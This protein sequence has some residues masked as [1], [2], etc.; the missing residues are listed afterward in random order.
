[1]Q[2]YSP[3]KLINLNTLV[4]IT[5]STLY[6]PSNT[7]SLRLNFYS[8]VLHNKYNLTLGA[9][10]V[11]KQIKACALSTYNRDK[12]FNISSC[13]RQSISK[14]SESQKVIKGPL[15]LQPQETCPL[16]PLLRSF[17]TLNLD[18]NLTSSVAIPKRIKSKGTAASTSMTN[19]PLR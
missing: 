8:D 7:S 1:M 11:H 17:L 9:L 6:D 5:F 16:Y 2:V 13:Q 12:H 19:Q 3:L 14:A 4:F 18:I 15:Q 10:T